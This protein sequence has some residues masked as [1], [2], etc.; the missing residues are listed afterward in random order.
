[1][2]R[3]YLGIDVGGS[4]IKAGLVDV[5]TGAMPGDAVTRIT[6]RP[7]TPAAIAD[8]IGEIAAR[9]PGGEHVGVGIPSVVKHG[10]AWTAA[11][12]HESWVGV[13]VGALLS[14]ALGRP[15][16]F[17]NDADAAGLAEMRFGAGRDVPGTV[18][19]L[20]L[21]TGIGSAPFVDGRLLPNTEFGHLQLHGA[22]AELYASA[23]V[24]HEQG[25]GWPEW[26]ARLT[27][28]L[29]Y[30]ERLFWPDLFILCGGVIEHFGEFAPYLSTRTPVVPALLGSSAGIVGAALAAAA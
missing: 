7:A 9:L 8:T 23:R 6:P 22:S 13:D 24:R 29:G 15:A 2:A 3:W 20:T 28:Y 27:E 16:T 17:L 10:K 12:I 1:M 4:S 18:M 21:G 11:N 26:G 30:M 25:L 14:G 5:D 19:V